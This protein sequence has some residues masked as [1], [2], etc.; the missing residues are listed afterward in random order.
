MPLKFALNALL[1]IILSPLYSQTLIHRIETSD[2]IREEKKIEM[3]VAHLQALPKKDRDKF[4]DIYLDFLKEYKQSFKCSYLTLSNLAKAAAFIHSSDA[5]NCLNSLMVSRGQDLD[6]QE[7]Y[8]ERISKEVGGRAA[9]S[10][11]RVEAHFER[12]WV[13]DPHG[14]TVPV[15]EDMSTFASLNSRTTAMASNYLPAGIASKWNH[16]A[17]RYGSEH[18]DM[19][20]EGERLYA[21]FVMNEASDSDAVFGQLG[22]RFLA[23]RH[24]ELKLQEKYF[25][26]VRNVAGT[27]DATR[28]IAI[29]DRFSVLF[30]LSPADFGN[31]TGR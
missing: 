9:L 29:T 7:K 3:A 21:D 20:H 28:F 11:L 4:K 17:S 26:E 18:H 6:I 25:E 14:G 27:P 8:F 12:M 30:Q 13:T 23:L 15:I 5:F 31:R 1:V 24:K 2:S 16:L 19:V 22:K 10:F